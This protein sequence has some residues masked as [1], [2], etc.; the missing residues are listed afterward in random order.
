MPK[1]SAVFMSLLSS[2]IQVMVLSNK[3]VLLAKSVNQSL[4]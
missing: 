2:V 3:E 1:K 4:S